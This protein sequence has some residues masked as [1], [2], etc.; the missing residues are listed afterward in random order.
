MKNEKKHHEG[1]TFLV[2]ILSCENHSWQGRLTWV[3]KQ[4]IENFRSALEL[5][6][7]MDSAVPSKDEKD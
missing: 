3:E 6:K 7:L 2:E 1:T 5:I 4:K